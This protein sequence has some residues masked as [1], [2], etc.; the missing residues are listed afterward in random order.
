MTVPA[1]FAE[2]RTA[3][4]DVVQE[5]RSNNVGVWPVAMQV[6]ITWQPAFAQATAHDIGFERLS[7]LVEQG[8]EKAFH[9]LWG[10]E[11]TWHNGQGLAPLWVKPGS[12]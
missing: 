2:V 5:W 8:V 6:P 1:S 10:V 11:I 3:F 12:K 7:M 9:S 4:L